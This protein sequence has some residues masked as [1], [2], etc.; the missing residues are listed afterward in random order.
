MHPTA[1]RTGLWRFPAG[2][3]P[4]FLAAYIGLFAPFGI[5]IPFFQV[6]LS[7]RGFNR[8]QVG[9]IQGTVDVL[10]VLAPPLLGLLSDRMGRAREVLAAVIIAAIPPLLLFGTI[11]TLP[12]AICT[13]F[14]F[15]LCFRPQ[16]ALTDGL[17][18]RYIHHHGGD[19]GPVRTGGSLSFIVIILILE[20][21]GVS[22][23]AQPVILTAFTI[24][25]M[26]QVV[27]VLRLPRDAHELAG[28]PRRALAP[29][30]ALL[31]R[32]V[33]C[34]TAAAFLGR[35]AMM[36]HYHFFSLFLKTEFDFAHA[37]YL[38]V[39][40]P[41]SEIPMLYYS[42]RI[43]GR[44]GIRS[45]FS[46]SLIAVAVRL[47]GYSLAPSLW[48]VVALQLLHTFTFG[49][50][51]AAAIAFVG[52]HAPPESKST[53]QALFAAFSFG[54]GGICGGALGGWIAENAGFTSL[55][56][57]FGAIALA[58]FA[59]TRIALTDRDVNGP[60]DTLKTDSRAA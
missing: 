54:L 17:T 43:M 52:R 20:M 42:G 16:V 9:V 25:A 26:L 13:A 45:L 48:I 40:G 19:Y 32:P 60:Q 44:F 8:Q 55:Y 41:I 5:I 12:A 11:T 57:V 15:G 24:T 18:L 3:G 29:L 50:F 22:R 58:G 2:V 33:L 30:R 4:R 51:H 7:E 56:R 46:A 53:A 38:W 35:M 39:I 34:F 6:L 28:R 21:A 23:N 37:G 1:P 31:S 47:L 59:L 49:A 36:S 27:T 10:S 14:C